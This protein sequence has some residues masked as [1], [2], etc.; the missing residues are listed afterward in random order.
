MAASF[1]LRKVL[2][3]WLLLSLLAV[4]RAQSTSE[5][6]LKAPIPETGFVSA[7]EYINPFF[8]FTLPLPRGHHFH[9]EDLSLSDK[10][11]Q[12]F[13]F[14]QKSFD[15]G[16][17]LL[18]VSATQVLGSPQDEAQKA[19]FLPGNQAKVGVEALDIGGRLFWKNQ[20]EQKTFGGKIFRARYTTGMA[21]FVVQFS[22]SSSNGKLVDEL[23]QT[24]ESIKFFDPSRVKEVTG[25]DSR[26]FLPEAARL[27][28]ESKPELDLPHL[29][30]GLVS[31]GSYT[32]SFLGFSFQFPTG[33]SVEDGRTEGKAVGTPASLKTTT[34]TEIGSADPCIRSLFS[35]HKLPPGSRS[36]DFNSHIM[37]LA[38]DPAC[39]APDVEFPSSVHDHSALQFLGAALLR[40]FAGSPLLGQN[41]NSIRAVD[42]RG[43]IF[44]ELPSVAAVPIPGSTLLR[45]VHKSF[46]LA[47]M[48]HYWVI[49]LF[50]CDTESELSR[51]MK[52][53]LSFEPN[54]GPEG[55][56]SP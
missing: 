28:I 15:K 3:A 23:K 29:D 51:L 1:C 4:A 13:L 39:F 44:L 11:L 42:L 6:S 35:A 53:S 18:V 49:W 56:G 19:A 9:N 24:V 52:A 31:D 46:V 54:P 37:I 27:R 7:Q 21:G 34:H 32:N 20:V 2:G 8:C 48:A 36:P 33:W 50:E 22:I 30:P 43:H 17:T 12:H 47:N 16:I 38:A 55:P 10:A 14:A 5:P 45:K 26:P 40:A 41:A 25:A